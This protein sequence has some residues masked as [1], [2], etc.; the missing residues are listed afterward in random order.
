MVTDQ[1]KITTLRDQYRSF[2]RSAMQVAPYLYTTKDFNE[3]CRK[4]LELR[5]LEPTPSN[6]VIAAE[7]I[8][9]S[10]MLQAD[11]YDDYIEHKRLE[12]EED[13]RQEALERKY[14]FLKENS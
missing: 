3:D 13:R 8:S 12:D 5:E 6:W 14:D 7:A 4:E 2:Q 1:F 11:E 10:L 9:R